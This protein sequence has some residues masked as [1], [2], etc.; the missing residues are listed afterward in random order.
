MCLVLLCS[1]VQL[2]CSLVALQADLLF[3]P[4]DACSV[5][6]LF[7]VLR[8][9]TGS[10]FIIVLII[11]EQL[12]LPCRLLVILLTASSSVIILLIDEQLRLPC[13]LLALYCSRLAVLVLY[14]SS[15]SSCDFHADLYYYTA[16]Q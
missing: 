11:D 15:L 10:S 6:L 16:H 13:R 1:P 12:Q 8:L 7:I 4:V 2:D 5:R 3:T 9:T 14:C